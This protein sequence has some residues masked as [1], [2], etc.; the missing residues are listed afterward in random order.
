MAT[1]HGDVHST[2]MHELNSGGFLIITAI[3]LMTPLQILAMASA[4][5]EF[6][7]NI[8]PREAKASVTIG[9]KQPWTHN[10]VERY[11]VLMYKNSPLAKHV[12]SAKKHQKKTIHRERKYKFCILTDHWLDGPA[13]KVKDL[14]FPEYFPLLYTL[15]NSGLPDYPSL[16][17]SICKA[18]G[19]PQRNVLPPSRPRPS[20]AVASS[21]GPNGICIAAG[22]GYRA[23][24]CEKIRSTSLGKQKHRPTK[25][26]RI[27][28]IIQWNYVEI[29]YFSR[30]VPHESVFMCFFFKLL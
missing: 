26:K 9:R 11:M 16:K 19:C 12:N 21:H 1:R 17:L 5:T 27:R 18:P 8:K 4:P 14:N 23:G 24:G 25:K 20:W 3:G 13:K 28:S 2:K 6:P 7:N 15:V 22:T 29:E 10:P 30:N